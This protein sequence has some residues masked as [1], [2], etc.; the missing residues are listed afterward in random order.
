LA[1]AEEEQ[2]EDEIAALKEKLV[3]VTKKCDIADKSFEHC[4][5]SRKGN[6][7]LAAKIQDELDELRG[8]TKLPKHSTISSTAVSHHNEGQQQLQKRNIT[9]GE[10]RGS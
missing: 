4:V 5:A 9:E 8:Q 6:L 10:V 7:V 2:D 1:E 3:I